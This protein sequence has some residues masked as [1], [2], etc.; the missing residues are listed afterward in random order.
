VATSINDQQTVVIG[1]L[2]LLGPGVLAPGE[3]AMHHD[4]EI[5]TVAPVGDVE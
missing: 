1:E 2:T 5:A 3:A 4:D